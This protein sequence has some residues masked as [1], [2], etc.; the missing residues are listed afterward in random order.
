MFKLSKVSR[1]FLVSD[2]R[3]LFES[4]TELSLRIF[5]NF[6]HIWKYV[7]KQQMTIYQNVFLRINNFSPPWY[8][9]LVSKTKF[10]DSHPKL[11][12]RI[13]CIAIYVN[14]ARHV[15]TR[16]CWQVAD[17]G[18]RVLCYGDERHHGEYH[19]QRISI[20]N[21]LTY[22]AF[23]LANTTNLPNDHFEVY[24]TYSI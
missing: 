11:I 12:Y 9:T 17:D 8:S 6:T 3:Y 22:C 4:I 10:L 14:Y 13:P 16:T 20:T 1:I 23:V 5:Q 19:R 18:P 2:Q 21:A 7:R 24:P 15:W